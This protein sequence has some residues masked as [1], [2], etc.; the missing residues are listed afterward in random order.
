MG[1]VETQ[2]KKQEAERVQ[3]EEKIKTLQSAL[4]KLQNENRVSKF[5]CSKQL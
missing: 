4:T 2:M 1:F 5:S 3:Q